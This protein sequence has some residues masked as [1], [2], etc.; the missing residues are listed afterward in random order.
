MKDLRQIIGKRKSLVFIDLEGTQFSHEMIALGG[1]K[2]D[3]HRNGTV[4]RIH[5]GFYRLVLAKNKVGKV[6]VELTGL[7]DDKLKKE[8]IRFRQAIL[9]F[10]K[11]VGKDFNNTLFI[12]YGNHD[13]R[14]LAQSL[15]YN[16]DAP[17]DDVKIM[18]K[19]F[20]DFSEWISRYVRD[21]NY[22]TYSLSNLLNLFGVEFA[23]E[24]H[25]AL[26]D[27]VNLVKLFDVVQKRKD[28]VQKEYVKTLS[29]AHG[30][31]GPVSALVKRILVDKQAT[32]YDDFVKIIGDSLND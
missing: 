5:R 4:K 6:V 23:G 8:G 12:A 21:D 13:A 19:H 24:K 10:K 26:A 2:V 3:L 14:I 7:T 32:S 18:I 28:I 17:T 9:E 27:T 11:Y 25:N 22:N 30:L 16:L 31:T 20:F 1:V 15:I 29:K